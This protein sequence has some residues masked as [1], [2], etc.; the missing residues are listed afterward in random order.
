[1]RIIFLCSF[2]FMTFSCNQGKLKVMD[3][4]LEK[5]AINGNE[6]A[7]LRKPAPGWITNTLINSVY[8]SLM[9]TKGVDTVLGLLSY[10]SGMGDKRCFTYTVYLT[11]KAFYC[12]H[13]R[14]LL[15]H[16][17]VLVRKIYKGLNEENLAITKIIFEYTTRG[18]DLPGDEE[19]DTHC[20][21]VRFGKDELEAGIFEGENI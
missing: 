14:G 9:N 8:D 6:R 1:M 2:L 16:A 17:Q 13:R 19:Y 12:V 4:Q 20:G 3:N 11:G 5:G 18:K 7:G 15:E 21:T 10:R